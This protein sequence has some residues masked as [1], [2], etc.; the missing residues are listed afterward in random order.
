MIMFKLKALLVSIMKIEIFFTLQKVNQNE[1]NSVRG[2]GG[3]YQT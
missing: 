1:L 3:H 2:R